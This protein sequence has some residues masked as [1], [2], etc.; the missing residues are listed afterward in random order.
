MTLEEKTIELQS[1]FP[2]LKVE[3][4][5]EILKNFTP[6]EEVVD[7]VEETPTEQIVN[8]VEETPTEQVV[9]ETEVTS[10]EQVP[11]VGNQDSSI[12]PDPVVEQTNNAGSDPL[13][14]GDGELPFQDYKFGE[15]KVGMSEK[16]MDATFDFRRKYETVAKQSEVY[17]PENDPYQYK[18]EL[19][20]ENK[21]AYY[22]K[23]PNDKDFVL[24]ED[25]YASIKIGQIFNHYDEDQLKIIKG[26]DKQKAL[27]KD[28]KVG[29]TL[30]GAKLDPPTTEIEKAG[31]FLTIEEIEAKR[32]NQK[33]RIAFGVEELDLDQKI[34]DEIYD[35][36]LDVNDY[37]SQFKDKKYTGKHAGDLDE[38]ISGIRFNQD[39]NPREANNFLN[40]ED[41][42]GFLNEEGLMN[43]Y[44]NNYYSDSFGN[45]GT[46]DISP[47]EYKTLELARQRKLDSYFNYYIQDTNNKHNK[48]VL[49]SYI[50]NNK[51]KFK[52]A[53]TLSEAVNMAEKIFEEKY[54]QSYFPKID[55]SEY[56]AF[57]EKQFP[58]LV[59][60]EKELQAARQRKSEELIE[61]GSSEGLL[62]DSF[63]KFYRGVMDRSSEQAYEIRDLLGYDTGVGRNLDAE[64]NIKKSFNE[65]RYGYVEGKTAEI[66]GV[67]YIKDDEGNIYNTTSKVV[68]VPSSE[69]E[70]KK[71]SSIL[72]ASKERASSFS[73]AGSTEQFFAT[74]GTMLFDISQIYSVGKVTKV[75]KLGKLV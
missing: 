28:L 27:E 7:E 4:I 48:Q 49:L 40:S 2:P 25:E 32:K 12:A 43:D 6:D 50:V 1:Q 36:N 58:Q 29:D 31:E 51:D 11:E 39:F 13:D 33:A 15:F 17:N 57:R 66:D 44:V 52:E 5:I 16:Q 18:F 71:V 20:P 3:Q 9:S 74:A 61:E 68:F 38:T 72:D 41:F 64:E 35:E 26:L 60:A 53:K 34:S 42:L 56:K 63:S 75:T 70:L 47:E 30:V 37:Y 23:G 19:T 10:N 59:Q 65:V 24:Q 73:G 8:Q 45:L 67:D 46:Y 14:S 54:D 55:Y 22:Y 69:E 62:Q 21:L